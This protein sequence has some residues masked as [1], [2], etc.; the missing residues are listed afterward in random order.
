MKN[1]RMLRQ[2]DVLLVE[3]EEFPEDA[4]KVKDRILAHGETTG[5]A[6]HFR[7]QAQVLRTPTKQFV[8]IIAPEP[9]VHDNP[10]TGE[11]GD[12]NPIMVPAGKYEV[13]L[14]REFN[15][16]DEEIRRVMD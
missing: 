6:H 5:H 13:K 3:I 12:H 8:E 14:Q 10:M 2:G 15:P 7:G 4:E 9:L 16:V 11:K 1:R